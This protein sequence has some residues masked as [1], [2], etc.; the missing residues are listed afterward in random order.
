MGKR[1]YYEVLGISR[2]ASDEDIRKAYRALARK[3]HPDVNKGPD[4]TAKFA[5]IQEAYD[6]LS[7]AGKRRQYDQF[8]TVS[9][10]ARGAGSPFNWQSAASSSGSKFEDFEDMF[11]AFFGGQGGAG[12]G[13]PFAEAAARS[14]GKATRGRAAGREEPSTI[15][16]DLEVT[17][18][19]AVRGGT[20]TLRVSEDGQYKTVEVKV[21]KG[22]ADGA[23][24]R[25]RVSGE[26]ELIL[27]VRVGGHPLFRRGREDGA[28][29]GVLNL[30]L[31][32]PL[33]IAEATLGAEV[34]VPTLEG[35]V[36]MMVPA[37]SGS[38]RKLRLRGKGIADAAGNTGDLFAVLKI[39]TPDGSVLSAEDRA[40]LERIS[41]RGGS[42]RS[43]PEWGS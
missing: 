38:G 19:T 11:D 37:G 24:L 28:E 26:T 7:D 27:R 14:R 15:E 5:E 41:A 17:F 10:G 40:A 32:L 18:M 16:R 36:N 22:I 43:G 13:G 21:P 6:V 31:D 3:F 42:P 12:M 20:E 33:T 35:S 39:V 9:D 8:G 30:Y 2:G 34:S 29:A 4:A 1:D 25:V 23:R